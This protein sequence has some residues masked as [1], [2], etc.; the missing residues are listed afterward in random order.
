MHVKSRTCLVCHF[1]ELS[2]R[3]NDIIYL[4][5]QVD[6]NWFEGERHGRVGIFPTNYVEVRTGPDCI[7][8]CEVS[9]GGENWP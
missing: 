8:L 1:R 9:C 3:K 5:R 6:K 7:C 2:F 4:L